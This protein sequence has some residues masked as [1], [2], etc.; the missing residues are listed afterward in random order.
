MAIFWTDFRD[1]TDGAPDKTSFNNW[2][3]MVQSGDTRVAVFNDDTSS[4]ERCLQI[5]QDSS[6]QVFVRC[7][8]LPAENSGTVELYTKFR[9]WVVTGQNPGSFGIF[10]MR[11][12]AQSSGVSLALIPA[13]NRLSLFLNDDTRN[14]GIAYYWFNW[15]NGEQ[16]HCRCRNEGNRYLAKIWRVGEAEPPGWQIDALRKGEP[17]WGY[18][19]VGNYSRAQTRF[20]LF[21]MGTDGSEAPKTD[22]SRQVITS[23]DGN[24]AVCRGSSSSIGGNF[25]VGRTSQ[26]ALPGRFAVKRTEYASLLGSF[27]VSTER[28]SGVVGRF[29]VSRKRYGNLPGRFSVAKLQSAKISGRFA[30]AKSQHVGLSGNFAV[31]R[32]VLP[33]EHHAGLVGRFAVSRKR[34]GKIQGEFAIGRRNTSNARGVF[35]VAV[36]GKSSMSGAFTISRGAVANIA[37]NFTVGKGGKSDLVGQFVVGAVESS[38]VG[39]RFAISRRSRS[40]MVGKFR[41]VLPNNGL[42]PSRWT[43]LPQNSP[44]R[45]TK[46][47]QNSPSRWTK[48]PPQ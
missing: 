36:A 10:C 26:L 12:T 7:K 37:G 28:R 32:A 40:S 11:Y 31:K 23:F 45:W 20:Y 24:F 9:S 47:P 44:S 19:G 1:E 2:E 41:V 27:A 46:L 16:L 3:R 13:Y 17:G 48:L 34:Y 42:Y 18:Y 15:A 8:A 29:A 35:T 14:E 30:V 22:P 6:A 25:A 38:S 5:K 39:G 4:N 33:G 43:K 21:G